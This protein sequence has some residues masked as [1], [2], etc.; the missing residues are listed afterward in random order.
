MFHYTSNS[1]FDSRIG[2]LS[3]PIYVSHIL[4]IFILSPIISNFDL[5]SYEGELSVLVTIFVSCLLVKKLFQI[6]SKIYEKLEFKDLRKKTEC[7][8]KSM[9]KE[10]DL[11]S[12]IVPVYNSADLVDVFFK[13]FLSIRQDCCY[14]LIVVDNASIDQTYANLL[15]Y[16]DAIPQL[17]VCSFNKKQSSYAARN[18]GVSVSKGN[19][20]AFVDF[21]CIVTEEYLKNINYFADSHKT[22]EI[23]AGAVDLYYVEKNVYEIFDKYA[24]LKQESR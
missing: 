17:R 20:L 8:D 24:N 12:I 15:K 6:Q 7:F 22:G 3:Y 9:K 16:E 10:T 23:V 1:K 2:E 21:D 5:D 14:E 4:V 19:I 11:V 13:V 18:Y